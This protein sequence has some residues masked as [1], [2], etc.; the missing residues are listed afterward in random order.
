AELG[1]CRAEPLPGGFPGPWAEAALGDNILAP[2]A[3]VAR[4]DGVAQPAAPHR[5]DAGHGWPQ[6]AGGGVRG[7]GGWDAGEVD[8]VKA[9]RGVGKERQLNGQTLLDSWIG[10]ALGPPPRGSLCRRSLCQ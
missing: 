10:T 5:A 2:G 3:A 9:R 6:M 4:R 8:G 1:A 7:P